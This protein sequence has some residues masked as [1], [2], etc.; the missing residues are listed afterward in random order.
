MRMGVGHEGKNSP[1]AADRE[2]TAPS[3]LNGWLTTATDK[4]P[5][6]FNAAVITAMSK[7]PT[8][9]LLRVLNALNAGY[10]RNLPNPT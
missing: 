1:P 8:G 9:G 4:M 10:C 2:R 3:K 6:S 7:T 5:A